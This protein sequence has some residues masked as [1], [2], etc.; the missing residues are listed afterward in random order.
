[1]PGELGQYFAGLELALAVGVVVLTRGRLWALVTLRSDSSNATGFE[2][3]LL[4]QSARKVSC[5]AGT[6]CAAIVAAMSCSARVA[7][8]R[9]AI[10]H[11]T[12]LRL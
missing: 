4:P 9:V 2:A 12:V 8:S 7:D 5:L 3:V 6:F 1:M 10:M 11:P